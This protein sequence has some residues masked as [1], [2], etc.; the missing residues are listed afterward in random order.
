MSDLVSH[1]ERR[2]AGSSIVVERSQFP[3]TRIF[4]PPERYA[5]PETL[6]FG[7]QKEKTREARAPFASEIRPRGSTVPRQASARRRPARTSAP[8]A[9]DT[10]PWSGDVECA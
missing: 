5:S 10:E 8:S 1:R 6:S 4:R 7:I 3:Q 9:R 2:G